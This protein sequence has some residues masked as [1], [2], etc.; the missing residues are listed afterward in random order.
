M[1]PLPPRELLSVIEAALLGSAA[2]SPAQRVEL[3]HAVRD[4]APTFRT[5]LSYPVHP[6]CWTFA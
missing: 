1:A 2:P 6:L 4:A 5:L 3:L